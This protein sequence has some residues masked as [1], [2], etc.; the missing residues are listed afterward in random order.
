MLGKQDNLIINRL[1][2]HELDIHGQETR[3]GRCWNAT[4]QVTTVK[5]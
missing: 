3:I 1:L 2:E 5:E 4:T